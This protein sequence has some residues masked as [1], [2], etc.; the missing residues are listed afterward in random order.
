MSPLLECANTLSKKKTVS[1]LL[2]QI[3]HTSPTTTFPACDAENLAATKFIHQSL[4]TIFAENART[5]V[6]GNTCSRIHQCVRIHECV[7]SHASLSV[8][9]SPTRINTE[10]ISQLAVVSGL[11]A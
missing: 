7:A 11:A 10:R 9:F 5:R 3:G 2:S 6:V 8:R 1:A 4:K